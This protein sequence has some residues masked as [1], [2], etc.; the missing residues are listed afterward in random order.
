MYLR[1]QEP[2]STDMRNDLVG[3]IGNYAEKRMMAENARMESILD[4]MMD[5]GATIKLLTECGMYIHVR[6]YYA[7][8][9]STMQFAWS[10]ELPTHTPAIDRLIAQMAW[11]RLKQAF[12]DA[13]GIE[14]LARWLQPRISTERKVKR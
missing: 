6:N 8:N 5:A 1:Y 7:W 13:T 11:R 9:G 10:T 2:K 3:I 4:E 12:M 14:R